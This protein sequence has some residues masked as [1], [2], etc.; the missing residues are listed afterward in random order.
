VP[1]ALDD[2][3]SPAIQNNSGPSQKCRRQ[4]RSSTCT[5]DRS[6]LATLATKGFFGKCRS[7]MINLSDIAITFGP[8]Q[9]LDRPADCRSAHTAAEAMAHAWLCARGRRVRAGGVVPA[10]DAVCAWWGLGAV[11]LD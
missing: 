5:V 10:V 4:A 8:D 1:D 9:R 3:A 7:A 2:A 11:L 6:H